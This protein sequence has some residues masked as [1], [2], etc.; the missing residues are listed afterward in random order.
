[1]AT[2][3][4]IKAFCFYA[5]K[6]TIKWFFQCHLGVTEQ[7]LACLFKERITESTRTVSIKAAFEPINA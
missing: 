3:Y 1:M 2:L 5:S 4:L 6:M 7:Y